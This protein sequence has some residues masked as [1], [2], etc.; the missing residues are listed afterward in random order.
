MSTKRTRNTVAEE[1]LEAL[2]S[3]VSEDEE[4]YVSPLI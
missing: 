1:E 3:D 4:E 2:P